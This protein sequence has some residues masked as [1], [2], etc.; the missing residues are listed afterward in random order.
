MCREG[1]S[2]REAAFARTR[3]RG[4]AFGRDRLA[5]GGLFASRKH[6]FFGVPGGEPP[7]FVAALGH[8][9]TPL[10][11]SVPSEGDNRFPVI[12][13]CRAGPIE[14]TRWCSFSFWR[15]RSLCSGS[16]RTSSIPCG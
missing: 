15:Q 12:S 5:Y 9:V 11:R 13:A 16:V 7:A 3:G 4:P 2:I 8:F 6:I 10:P 14:A 1:V